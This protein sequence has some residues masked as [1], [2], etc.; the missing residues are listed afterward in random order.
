MEKRGRSTQLLADF[1]LILNVKLP[2]GGFTQPVTR[3]T[4]EDPYYRI[5]QADWNTRGLHVNLWRMFYGVETA[6]RRWG[7]VQRTFILREEI[8]IMSPLWIEISTEAALRHFCWLLIVEASPERSKGSIPRWY[9]LFTVARTWLNCTQI[10]TMELFK[11]P[12]ILEQKRRGRGGGLTLVT[13]GKMMFHNKALQQSWKWNL[14]TDCQS[15]IFY[16]MLYQQKKIALMK[17]RRQQP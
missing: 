16:N 12:T 13:D 5:Y 6:R 8:I 7:A 4:L 3:I 11:E 17:H 9:R 2:V 14:W 1:S 10:R 15:V